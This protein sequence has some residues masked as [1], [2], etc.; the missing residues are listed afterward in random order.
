[1]FMYL[2]EDFYHMVSFF[3]LL[4]SKYLQKNFRCYTD[5]INNAR[6]KEGRG[7]IEGKS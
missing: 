6:T 5:I 7:L 3:H 4:V 2:E 1:M